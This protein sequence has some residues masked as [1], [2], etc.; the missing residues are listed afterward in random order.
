L[1]ITALAKMSEKVKIKID[2]QDYEVP[3]GITLIQACDLVGVEI[4][5]FCYH[6]RLSIAGNCRMCLVELSVGPPKPQASCATQIFDGLEVKTKSDMVKKARSGAMEFLLANH[7]L[8]CPICDQGGECDLQDQAMFYGCSES[9]FLEDKRAVPEKSFGPLI[10]THMTRC[11]HCT[12]CVRFSTEVAGVEE[13]GAVGRGENMEVS[14]YVA[15]TLSSE[16]SGNII[17]LCPVGAL[18]SKPYAFTARPWELSKT[19]SIDIHDAVG[20]NIRI[21]SK[22]SQVMRI[23]PRLN[24]DINEEW[25]SDK[26]RFSYDGLRLQR[27]DQPYIRKSGKLV[28][29]SFKEAINLIAK[30]IEQ[31]QLLHKEIAALAGDL[32]DLES[33]YILKELLD[34]L[35]CKNYD[36]RPYGSVMEYKQRSDYLFN[37]KINNIEEADLCLI[38]SANPRKEAAILNARIRKQYLQNKNFV[39]ANIG[40]ENDLSYPYIQLGNSPKILEDILFGNNDFSKKLKAAKKPLIIIGEALFC[41]DDAGACL[42]LIQEICAKY[43]VVTNGWNGYNIL[44]NAAAR[45]G[46]LDID[47]A[48][49]SG[50]KDTK[51]IYQAVEN[52]KINLLFLLGYDADNM[53]KLK[54]SFN[55][56]IGTHGDKAVQYADIILPSVC[57]TEK[58]A[59]YVNLEGLLQSTNQ[60]V[61]PPAGALEDWQIINEIKKNLQ[62]KSYKSYKVLYEEMLKSS[63]KLTSNHN[64][65]TLSKYKKD[66]LSSKEFTNYIDNFYQTN[67]ITRASVTMTK[68]INEIVNKAKND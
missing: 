16:L 62:L 41:R 38:I 61:N 32:A 2:G 34:E 53:K 17:D 9:R 66:S 20:S 15:K 12:R 44:H 14:T 7:P 54:N 55:I 18:T 1:K 28:K 59:H 39:I 68:C 33:L 21:D 22:G 3:K 6:D 65:V 37:S 57:Y 56:Y 42:N 13:L 52:E 36:S 24:E 29:V 48:P 49:K 30:K 45:V 43:H 23:L 50:G 25:I 10:K 58:N 31:A 67:V 46:A 5:R 60:A 19:D 8:D 27:I 47:F 64:S 40:L 35:G 26:T 51:E 11:I 4:P 63:P